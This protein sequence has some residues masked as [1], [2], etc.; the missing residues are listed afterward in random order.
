MGGE[1]HSAEVRAAIAESLRAE[2]VHA[3]DLRIP[4]LD[5]PF[6]G[7]A[8]RPL[9]VRVER[10]AISKTERDELATGDRLRRTVTFDLPRGAYATVVLRALGH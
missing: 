6:F 3:D 9:A 2:N 5:R 7:A 10:F 8:W 1:A 4:G